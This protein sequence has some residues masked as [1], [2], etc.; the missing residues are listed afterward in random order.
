M[1][2]NRAL[3]VELKQFLSVFFAS[4]THQSADVRTFFVNAVA[5]VVASVSY[6]PNDSAYHT[7][8]D[9]DLLRRRVFVSAST[10]FFKA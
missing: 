5:D 1:T 6:A 4:Y 2:D 8:R 3:P 10:P 7:V 9:D